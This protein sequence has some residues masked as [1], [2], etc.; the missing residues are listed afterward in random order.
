[1]WWMFNTQM[2]W[3]LWCWML[4]L[5]W[6]NIHLK[7]VNIRFVK[8]KT[9]YLRVLYE[10]HVISIFFLQGNPHYHPWHCGNNVVLCEL[11]LKQISCFH[12]QPSHHLR[13]N[14][15]KEYLK[16]CYKLIY[17]WMSRNL[18]WAVNATKL[19]HHGQQVS[20]IELFFL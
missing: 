6:M 15:R 19:F 18:I 9:N 3:M 4:S 11:A 16:W 1:M 5:C 12:F 13:L 8:N 14:C 17:W 2:W 7:H 10:Y 20:A